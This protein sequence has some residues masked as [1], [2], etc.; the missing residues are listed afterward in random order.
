[1][2][3]HKC[4]N[5]NVWSFHAHFPHAFLRHCLFGMFVCSLGMKMPFFLHAQI[6]H[7]FS[8]YICLKMCWDI[9]GMKFLQKLYVCI[10]LIYLTVFPCMHCIFSFLF[11]GCCSFS[12]ID[13]YLS[14]ATRKFFTPSCLTPG[15]DISCSSSTFT[16][17]LNSFFWEF[18]QFHF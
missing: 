13:S 12:L 6:P 15:S 5:E 7:V 11:W 3:F 9:G 8:N 10:L 16:F 14:F 2:I 1:M 18:F 17:V 4:H